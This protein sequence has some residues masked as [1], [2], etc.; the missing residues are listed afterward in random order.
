MLAKRLIAR[1]DIKSPCLVKTIRL[2][3]VRQLGDPY[4]YA[5]R[6]DSQGIDEIIFL[7]IVASLYGRN[8]LADLVS[9]AVQGVFCPVTVG[10]GIRSVEDVR[11]LLNA[12]ADVV[13]VNTAATERPELIT[14]LA[15]K[16]GSQCV[17]IQIDA[18]KNK[19]GWEAWKNGGREPTGFDVVVWAKQA[20]QLG[21]GGILL[22]SIDREGLCF[23]MDVDLIKA[24]TSNISVP[25]VA[26]GGVG[27]P[28]HVSEAFG[29]GADGV[30]MAHVL[31]YNTLDLDDIRRSVSNAGFRVRC[32]TES[33]VSQ[34]QFGTT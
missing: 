15:N 32:E 13:A 33:S 18:K 6:Y 27:E 10:G 20:V 21:A 29:A 28:R 23:G 31:H 30:A 26:S 4:E 12:G 2:E 17:T 34:G 8:H 11:I 5:T 9:R 3:G 25:V 24:V 1:L 19:T 16:Y 7:D 14:E 22:T